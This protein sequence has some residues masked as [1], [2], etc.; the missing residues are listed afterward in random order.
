MHSNLASL[1][2]PP[3]NISVSSDIVIEDDGENYY[4]ATVNFLVSN[5]AMYMIE[6]TSLLL[7]CIYLL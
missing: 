4:S 3:S 7:S 1:T 2:E 6:K 5:H